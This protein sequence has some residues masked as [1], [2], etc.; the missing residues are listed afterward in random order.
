MEGGERKGG[1]SRA[2]A[3]N[4]RDRLIV[5]ELKGFAIE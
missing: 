5:E 1:S 3:E 4:E 2:M